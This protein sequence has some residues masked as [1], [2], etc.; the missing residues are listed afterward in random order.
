MCKDLQVTT[1]GQTS[2]VLETKAH[3]NVQDYSS[4]CAFNI[5]TFCDTCCFSK[6]ELLISVALLGSWIPLADSSCE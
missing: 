3:L 5:S 4:K 1:K 6:L 2:I